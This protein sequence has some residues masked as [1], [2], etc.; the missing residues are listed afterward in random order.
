MLRWSCL[1]IGLVLIVIGLVQL[2]GNPAFAQAGP[3]VIMV[4]RMD[5]GLP[6]A[7]GVLCCLAGVV[8]WLRSD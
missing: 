2:L 5:V 3:W 1:L 8:L 7:A 6:L 4:N